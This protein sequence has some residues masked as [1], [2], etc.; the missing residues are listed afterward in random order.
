MDVVLVK[1]PELGLLLVGFFFFFFGFW[2]IY[3]WRPTL[4]FMLQKKLPFALPLL[5]FGIAVQ[6]IAGMM[7]MIQ[8]QV[9]LAALVLIPFDII[10][11][12]IFHAFWNFSG[13]IRRLNTII[14]I[15]NLTASLA[16]LLLALAY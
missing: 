5:S 13:E 2:N 15:T 3:H 7:L 4:D 16:A 12:F 11:V 9:K 14:F 1:A 10:A 6:L 8:F